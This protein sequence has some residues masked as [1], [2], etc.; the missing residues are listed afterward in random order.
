MSTPAKV[1]LV[2]ED[3]SVIRMSAAAVLLDEGFGVLEA[4]HANA[5]KALLEARAGDVHVLFTDIHMPGEMNGL[6]LA[7]HTSWCWPWIAIIVT[8]GRGM[9]RWTD[10][11]EGCRYLPKPYQHEHLIAHCRWLPH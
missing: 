2:V 11:P 6:Q 5:A 1:V 7:H 3:E 8:S 4:E 10:L 9:P